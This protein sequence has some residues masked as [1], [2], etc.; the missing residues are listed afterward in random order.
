MILGMDILHHLHLYI[1]YKEKKLYIT[2]AS[3][4]APAVQ[5]GPAAATT[6]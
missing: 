1:A 5:P 6:H 3:A 4:P 2:P